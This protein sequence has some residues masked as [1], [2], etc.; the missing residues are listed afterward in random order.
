[1][2]KSNNIGHFYSSLT[3]PL[4]FFGARDQ[5]RANSSESSPAHMGYSRHKLIATGTR[6]QSFDLLI[7]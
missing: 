6:A 1:M 2:I 7:L 4:F 5:V 3:L